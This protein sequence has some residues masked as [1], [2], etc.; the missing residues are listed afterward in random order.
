MCVRSSGFHSFPPAVEEGS[1]L[2]LNPHDGPSARNV[3]DSCLWDRPPLRV[4]R[5][6]ALASP[7][8][9]T[10]LG[11]CVFKEG[12]QGPWP[13]G[14]VLVLLVTHSRGSGFPG[15][16][17][18]RVWGGGELPRGSLVSFWAGSVVCNRDDWGELFYS[19]FTDEETIT[20]RSSILPQV[21]Q[22]V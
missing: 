21:T 20:K 19:H 8:R 3:L 11:L 13:P 22:Q 14:P 10:C 17:A 5:P 15:V 6:W 18:S 9:G 16:L 12:Q 7:I 2:T 4:S 1:A